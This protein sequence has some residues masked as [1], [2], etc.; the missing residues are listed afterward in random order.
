ME[1][2]C[3]EQA[4]GLA[5]QYNS[6]FGKPATVKEYTVLV[7]NPKPLPGSARPHSFNNGKSD[8]QVDSKK[9]WTS[10]TPKRVMKAEPERKRM[11]HWH[12][13]QIVNSS[14]CGSRNFHYVTSTGTAVANVC[15]K[16]KQPEKEQLKKAFPAGSEGKP[17]FANKS[18][19]SAAAIEYIIEEKMNFRKRWLLVF[20]KRST[21]TMLPTDPP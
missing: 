11:P 15:Y 21:R 10:D 8:G 2:G 14:T 6:T 3:D 19:L 16:C 12:C 5:V 1:E 20:N 13:G 18:T 4:L 9:T 7:E 17:S